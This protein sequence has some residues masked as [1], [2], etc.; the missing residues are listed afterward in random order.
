L[1]NNKA[2]LAR[3]QF[4]GLESTTRKAKRWGLA[5]IQQTGESRPFVCGAW[6]LCWPVEHNLRGR[7][8]QLEYPDIIARTKTSLQMACEKPNLKKG[9]ERF[10]QKSRV[11]NQTARRKVLASE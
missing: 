9:L 8:S 3:R 5:R 7:E 11:E 6:M 10:T 1:I 4:E 2:L